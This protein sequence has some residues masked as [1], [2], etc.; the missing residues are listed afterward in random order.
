MPPDINELVSEFEKTYPRKPECRVCATE[1]RE[2][3]DVLFSRGAGANSVSAF[4]KR[5]LDLEIGK[6]AL[7]RH[8]REHGTS[9]AET[10]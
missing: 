6:D 7:L 9:P 1:W 4:M 2:L 8:R 5:K 3:I 10:V